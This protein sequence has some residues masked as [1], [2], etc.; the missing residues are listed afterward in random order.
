MVGPAGAGCN[1]SWRVAVATIHTLSTPGRELDLLR[2]HLVLI[3]TTYHH[4]GITPGL[5]TPAADQDCGDP[6]PLGASDASPASLRLPK[7]DEGPTGGAVGLLEQTIKDPRIVHQP[8]GERKELARLTTRA[9]RGRYAVNE[10]AS[11]G[12]LL[13]N[14]GHC[15]EVPSLHA[16]SVA[17]RQLGV[18]S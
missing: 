2:R 16:L 9:A 14:W 5:V 15:C 6:A 7:R 8:G 1:R 18:T 13:G 3:E 12:Y 10:L 4:R 17:L 11:G